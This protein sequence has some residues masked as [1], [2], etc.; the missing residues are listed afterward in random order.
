MN[1]ILISIILY[2]LFLWK[3]EYTDCHKNKTKGEKIVNPMI[4]MKSKKEQLS[5]ETTSNALITKD[6]DIKLEN[7]NNK[8]EILYSFRK[9]NEN[10]IICLK[11]DEISRKYSLCIE[12]NTMEGYYPIYNKNK[13]NNIYAEYVECYNENTKPNNTFFNKDLQAYEKCYESC[14]IHFLIKIYKPMRNAMNLVK[15]ALV[16]VIYIII[17]VLFVKKDLFLILEF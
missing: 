1:Y 11:S 16:M 5:N 10:E 2:L 3:Y 4:Y 17:I 7:N 13:E 8:N 12:C 6:Y 9:L 15:L 14:E